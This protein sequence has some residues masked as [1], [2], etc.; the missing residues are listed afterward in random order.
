MNKM[1]GKGEVENQLGASDEQE[2]KDSTATSQS[3]ENL[4]ATLHDILP[5]KAVQHPDETQRPAHGSVSTQATPTEDEIYTDLLACYQGGKDD[6][7]RGANIVGELEKYDLRKYADRGQIR[8]GAG[9]RRTASAWHQCAGAAL[10][11][12]HSGW[13]WRHRSHA[14]CQG[15]SCIRLSQPRTASA[16]PNLRVTAP[17]CRCSEAPAGLV[18]CLLGTFCS[19]T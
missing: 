9:S 5:S 7:D 4:Q 6:E 11:S 15:A 13:C 19:P 16:K 2:N 18:P 3:R 1:H 14:E 8:K 10:R 12:V 17:R